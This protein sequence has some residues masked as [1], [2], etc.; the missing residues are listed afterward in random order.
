ML[1]RSVKRYA[2]V[3][4]ISFSGSTREYSFHSMV[5]VNIL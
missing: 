2:I 1:L 5:Y 4:M 3:N